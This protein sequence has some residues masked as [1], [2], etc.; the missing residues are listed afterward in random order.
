MVNPKKWAFLGARTLGFGQRPVFSPWRLG[1]Y[2]TLGAIFRLFVPELRPFSL[3][4]TWSTRQKVFPLPTVRAPSASNSP[5]A[6]SAQDLWSSGDKHRQS[7]PQ[8]YLWFFTKNFISEQS[9][10]AP[11]KP[12]LQLSWISL[13]RSKTFPHLDL[14]SQLELA[15]SWW[16]F[17]GEKSSGHEDSQD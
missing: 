10:C 1:S 15:F 8:K 4:K 13:T 12:Q 16:I 2:P 6:L 17:R 11:T 3:K 14:A 7:H 5:S 9:R